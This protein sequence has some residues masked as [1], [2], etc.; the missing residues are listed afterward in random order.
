MAFSAVIRR[1]SAAAA[2]KAYAGFCRRSRRSHH[3]AALQPFLPGTMLSRGERNRVPSSISPL[4]RFF[5]SL[6]KKQDAELLQ[7][8]ES[9]IQCAK[10][11]IREVEEVSKEFPF[12]IQDDEG[13]NI[14]ILRREYFGENIEVVVSMP[15]I[16]VDPDHNE[17]ED[18]QGSRGDEKANQPTIPLTVNISK[19][20]G[21]NLE[22]CCTAYA[23]E[24][25]VD[26]LSLH[27][28]EESED[29]LL[30]YEGPDFDDLDENL[31]K[32]FQKY[33]EMR[34]ISPSTTSYLYEY[35]VNKEDREYLRW[36]QTVRQFIEK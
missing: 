1:A 21:V 30:A 3:F 26:S 16:D 15:N 22:F 24:L 14:V 34:A 32:A 18:D 28:T 20:K 6:S 25:V 35:M 33:L 9:E 19:G 23:D 17:G 12:E 13:A 11:D 36:M 4:A 27:K 10:E 29:R 7:I 8:I 31:R 2:V 5:S